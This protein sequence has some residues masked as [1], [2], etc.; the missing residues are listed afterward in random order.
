MF[1]SSA[2]LLT[3]AMPGTDQTKDRMIE[4]Q[5]GDRTP[6]AVM[7]MGFQRGNGNQAPST[8]TEA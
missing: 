2:G 1:V 6:P 4:G 8:A 5:S 7:P 3:A